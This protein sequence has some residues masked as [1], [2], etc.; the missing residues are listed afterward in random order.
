MSIDKH[1]VQVGVVTCL[2]G[3]S[4]RE[5]TLVWL[6]PGC[7]STASL[8]LLLIPKSVRMVYRYTLNHLSEINTCILC[9][10]SSIS[11]KISFSST[12]IC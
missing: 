12:G 10:S 5:L 11:I 7:G 9:H 2:E 3:N 4:S 6:G 1:S 8:H